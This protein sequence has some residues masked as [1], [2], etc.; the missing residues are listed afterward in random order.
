MSVDFDPF[1]ELNQIQRT[2]CRNG[3]SYTDL[4]NERL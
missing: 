2:E 4:A 1:A 3:L